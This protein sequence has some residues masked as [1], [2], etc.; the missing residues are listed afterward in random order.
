MVHDT[1]YRE[2]LGIQAPA[3]TSSVGI[4]LKP[5]ACA[6]CK[7]RKV[8]CDHKLPCNQ[9][10]KR[11]ITCEYDSQPNTQEDMLS[12]LISEVDQL[13][14]SLHAQKQISEYWRNLYQEK[15]RIDNPIVLTITR[16][17]QF[18]ESTIKFSHNVISAVEKSNMAFLD[19]MN[20]LMPNTTSE[21]SPEYSALIWNRLVDSLPE[22]LVINIRSMNIEII[23]QML[24]QS[25]IFALGK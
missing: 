17:P 22:D 8:R 20:P 13:K 3:K 6:Y 23:T 1:D 7:R 5:P 24:Y 4:P 25:S 10:R 16:R 12:K 15:S 2:I 21:Y 9:C 18:S 19:I 14:S 11:K